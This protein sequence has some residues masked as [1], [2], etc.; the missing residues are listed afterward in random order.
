MAKAR[1]AGEGSLFRRK[2]G[3]WVGQLHIG[4]EGGRRKYRYVHGRREAEVRERL[5][6]MARGRDLGMLSSSG[7][8]TTGDDLA[9]WLRD[10]ARN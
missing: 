2:D 1:A 9:G 7:R 10:V 4:W 8:Q 3:R 5:T 6:Q